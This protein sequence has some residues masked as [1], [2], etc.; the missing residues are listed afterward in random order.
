VTDRGSITA[1]V[2]DPTGAR[3]RFDDL[4]RIDFDEI[5]YR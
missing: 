5:A 1:R 2:V 4:T 3:D